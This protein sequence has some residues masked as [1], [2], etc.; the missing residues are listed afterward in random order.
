MSTSKQISSRRNTGFFFVNLSHDTLENY[1]RTNFQLMQNFNYTLSDLDHMLPWER[2]VY[3]T[4]L[5]QHLEEQ[6]QQNGNA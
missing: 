3:I 1:Y 5:L 2:E 6:R 4:M